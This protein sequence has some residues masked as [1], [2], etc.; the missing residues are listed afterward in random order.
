MWEQPELMNGRLN[1]EH[2]N[3]YIINPRSTVSTTLSTAVSMQ[4]DM[5]HEVSSHLDCSASLELLFSQSRSI[6]LSDSGVASMKL[7]IQIVHVV[8]SKHRVRQI[9]IAL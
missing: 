6:N 3:I 4:C 7:P 8:H 9:L 2:S 5:S 1:P